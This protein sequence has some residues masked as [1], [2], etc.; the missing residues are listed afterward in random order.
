M[1]GPQ[2][3]P[4]SKLRFNLAMQD[5]NMPSPRFHT[6]IF[7]ETSVGGLGTGIKHHITG[8]IVTGIYYE[9]RPS[10]NPDRSECLHHKERIGY[11][12]A[13]TYLQEFDEILLAVQAPTKHIAST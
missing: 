3:Y 7:I 12:R 13:L 9:S 6:L 11:T 2:W 4:V 8:D 1:S 5:P 10:H